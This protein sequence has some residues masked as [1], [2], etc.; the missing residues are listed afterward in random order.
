MQPNII[1]GGHHQDRRGTIC[2]NNEFD[3]LG[4]KRVYTIQN[5]DVHFVR[6]W[7]GHRVEQRWFSAISGSFKI[8]LIRVDHWEEPSKNLEILAFFLIAGNLDV[9]HV[10]PGF[11][12]SIQAMDDA[13]Q[14]L[15]FADF[16]LGELQDEYRFPPDYFN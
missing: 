1:S 15:V 4:I 8:K 7:Q 13:S 11:I 16:R 5:N 12:S 2:F 3:L 14:L 10:P 9:L 6:A